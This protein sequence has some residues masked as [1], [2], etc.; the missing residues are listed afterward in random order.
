MSFLKEAQIK[1]VSHKLF[2]GIMDKNGTVKPMALSEAR[3]ALHAMGYKKI[4]EENENG[5][6]IEIWELPKP[7]QFGP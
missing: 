7:G 5:A 6:D 1:L 2:A 4:R 3:E